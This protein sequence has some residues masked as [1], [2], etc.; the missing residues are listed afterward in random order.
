MQIFS[1]AEYEKCWF[2]SWNKNAIDR[3][4]EASFTIINGLNLNPKRK[5]GLSVL[6][7]SYRGIEKSIKFVLVNH[8]LL[9]PT[10]TKT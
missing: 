8:E 9:G 6:K 5:Q 3:I 2:K 4:I 10:E 1:L 7:V